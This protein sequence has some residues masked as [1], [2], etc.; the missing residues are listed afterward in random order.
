MLHCFSIKMKNTLNMHS[1]GRIANRWGHVSI[2]CLTLG[3]RRQA[4][5]EASPEGSQRGK[6]LIKYCWYCVIGFIDLA[7]GCD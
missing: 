4:D 5:A 2:N 7:H 6:L 3:S 1:T